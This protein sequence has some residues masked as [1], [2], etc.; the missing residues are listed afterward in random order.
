MTKVANNNTTYGK[1]AK[2]ARKILKILEIGC[3]GIFGILITIAYQHY[4]QQQ[5]QIQDEI[6]VNIDGQEISS[7]KELFFD[8][9]FVF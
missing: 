7:S 3:S 4:N 5:N 2:I 9:N 1:K 6:I 8:S